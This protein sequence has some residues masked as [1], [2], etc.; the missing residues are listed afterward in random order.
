[1]GQWVLDSVILTSAAAHALFL[2]YLALYCSRLTRADSQGLNDEQRSKLQ[3]QML[4]IYMDLALV[5]H[6]VL[7]LARRQAHALPTAWPVDQQGARPTPALRSMYGC[8]VVY[9]SGPRSLRAQ[10]CH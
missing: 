2:T 4:P 3:V 9:V 7:H 5:S 1:M 8:Q 6:I 10:A